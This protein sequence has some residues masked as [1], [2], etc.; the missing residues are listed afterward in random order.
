M[1]TQIATLLAGDIARLVGLSAEFQARYGQHYILRPGSERAAWELFNAITAL[2]TAIAGRLDLEALDKPHMTIGRWW[3]RFDVPDFA[4]TKHLMDTVT[5][6]ISACAY[7]ASSAD[8]GQSHN[9]ACAQRVIAGL[10]HP[11]A[12]QLAQDQRISS[13]Q[14]IAV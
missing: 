11:S 9:A 3:E 13:R 5:Q 8:G 6:L 10:L 4:V 12:V 14:R 2:Q 7:D 1:N